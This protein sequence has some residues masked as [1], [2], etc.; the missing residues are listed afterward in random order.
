MP[1]VG[2]KTCAQARENL[3]ALGWRL[4]PEE[5]DA[6]DQAAARLKKQSVQNIFQSA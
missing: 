1:V 5:M 6:L 3:G 2:V 4:S